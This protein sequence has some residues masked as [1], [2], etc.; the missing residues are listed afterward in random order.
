MGDRRHVPL[1]VDGA[2]VVDRAFGYVARRLGS[3]TQVSRGSG[4][5]WETEAYLYFRYA[6][7]KRRRGILPPSQAE[8][9]SPHLS[10][11]QV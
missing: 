8:R 9:K 3:G 2:G 6:L 11:K 1:S 4:A 7:A 10:G 5:E